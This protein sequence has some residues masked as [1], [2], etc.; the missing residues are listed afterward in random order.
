MLVF[1]ALHVALPHLRTSQVTDHGPRLVE[2]VAEGSLDAAFVAIAAQMELPRGV[3]HQVVGLDPL[4]VLVPATCDLRSMGRRQLTG[5]AVATYTIDHSGEELDRRLVALGAIPNRAAT[6]ETAVR[7]G[8][9]LGNPVVLPRSLLRA[10]LIDGDRELAVRFGGPRLSLVSRLPIAPHWTSAVPVVPLRVLRRQSPF[11]RLIVPGR[12]A[13][14]T[15]RGQCT[16]PRSLKIRTRSPSDSPRASASAGCM[17]SFASGRGSCPSVE[18]IVRSLA[19]EM[20]ASG[21]LSVAGSG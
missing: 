19:G 16:S 14:A 20:S 8:R 4:A 21:Y 15:C 18:L 6:A 5:R 17:S 12:M 7:L 9:M 3:T 1:P 10:Y 2:W 11:G 13:A